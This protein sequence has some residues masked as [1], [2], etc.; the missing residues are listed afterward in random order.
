MNEENRPT[1]QYVPPSSPTEGAT[2]DATRY[3]KGTPRRT[4]TAQTQPTPET[5]PSAS[6]TE[7]VSDNTPEARTEPPVSEATT[8]DNKENSN[9]SDSATPAPVAQP[10]SYSQAQP[11]Q[12]AQDYT[13]RASSHGRQADSQ[14]QGSRREGRREGHSDQPRREGNTEYRRERSRYDSQSSSTP[15]Q[16]PYADAKPKATLWGQIVAFIRKCLG[17]KPKITYS[18]GYNPKAT[19]GR[20]PQREGSAPRDGRPYRDGG[21]RR[22]GRGRGGYNRNG[23]RRDFQNNRTNHEQGESNS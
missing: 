15:R 3:M 1:W 6:T 9:N 22:G 17:I 12:T 5:T 18:K 13:P 11:R 4:D 19:G 16:Q 8:N 21:R 14:M 2:V 23:P 7:Q 20:Y 10:R